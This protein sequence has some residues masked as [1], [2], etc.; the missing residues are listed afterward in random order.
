MKFGKSKTMYYVGWL[1]S[2]CWEVICMITVYIRKK[3]TFIKHDGAKHK[4]VF[5]DENE[6]KKTV[7]I[8]NGY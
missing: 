7:V 5:L 6:E 8:T 4:M 3:I 2:G 1:T